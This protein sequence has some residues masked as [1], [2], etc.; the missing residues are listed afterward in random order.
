M[1]QHHCN[2]YYKNS[3]KIS[4][5]RIDKS[6][7]MSFKLEGRLC[8]TMRSRGILT[9]TLLN[10]FLLAAHKKYKLNSESICTRIVQTGSMKVESSV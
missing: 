6:A 4:Y 2:H 10:I 1:T 8:T 3:F 5:L 7:F 9:S